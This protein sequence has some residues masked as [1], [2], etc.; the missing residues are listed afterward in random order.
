MDVQGKGGGGKVRSWN[1]AAQLSEAVDICQQRV[2]ETDIW[3]QG[4]GVW[5]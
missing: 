2:N 5:G 3:L 4:R 1:D